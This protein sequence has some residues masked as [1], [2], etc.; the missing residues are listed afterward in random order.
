MIYKFHKT[1]EEYWACEVEAN[2][3]EEAQKIAANAEWFEDGE[4]N[5]TLERWTKFEKVDD[6]DEQDELRSD[7]EAEYQII[8]SA[9]NR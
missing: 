9:Y 5:L 1:F 8:W 2:S 6:E 3:L 7:A 4:R